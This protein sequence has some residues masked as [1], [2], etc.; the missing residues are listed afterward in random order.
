[1][2][3]RRILTLS[4][5]TT[6]LLHASASPVRAENP[7]T[8]LQFAALHA[9]G[10]SSSSSSES[11]PPTPPPKR[12]EPKTSDSVTGLI[13][14]WRFTNP[15]NGWSGTRTFRNGGTFTGEGFSGVGKWSVEGDKVIVSYPNGRKDQMFLPLDPKNTKVIIKGGRIIGAAR[16]TTDLATVEVPNLTLAPLAKDE[17]LWSDRDRYRFTQIPEMFRGYKFTRNL[18]HSPTL[19]FKVLTDGRVYLACTGRW[20]QPWL[21][22]SESWSEPAISEEKLWKDGWTP[23][24]SAQLPTTAED[25]TWRVFSR[26]CKAGEHFAYRTEK[27]ASPILLLK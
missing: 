6:G 24:R 12:S 9:S 4:L 11:E 26:P 20:I 5:L 1:M 7:A 3:T 22:E 19:R 14:T 21:K 16:E 8:P 15:E 25:T 23:V 13:G 27:Y 18:A 17:R 2:N 10:S